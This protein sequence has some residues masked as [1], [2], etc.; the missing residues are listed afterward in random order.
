LINNA[1]ITYR[2]VLEH[3]SEADELQQL[4]TN[5]FGPMALIRLVLPGMR[6]RRWGRIINISSVGGMMAMPTMGSYSAS[7]FALEGASEALWYELLPWKIAVILV[8]PGFINSNS[9]R[10]V[11]W[12]SKAK[13]SLDSGDGYAVY[14]RQMN[15]FIEKLMR[16]A[17]ATPESIA[18]KVVELIEHPNPAL[19]IPATYDAWFFSLLRRVLPR[20]TYHWM[21]Y[22]N[23][24]GI[25]HWGQAKD[26]N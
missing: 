3:M 13:A 12:T 8:Q 14:Y 15:G 11:Y 17:F 6:M 16:R 2:A 20:R 7:K 19:R 22:R 25:E 4:N 23:L 21:L 24:P 10:N 1:G 18:D 26:E 9:F 5:F